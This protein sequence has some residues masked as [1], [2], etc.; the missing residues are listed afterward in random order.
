MKNLLIVVNGLIWLNERVISLSGLF[1][2]F[3][4][5]AWKNSPVKKLI[6]KLIDVVLRL[7]SKLR[8]YLEYIKDSITFRILYKK[9]TMPMDIYYREL[10][11]NLN[12]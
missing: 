6:F 1:L 2:S 12:K 7:F 8:G 11:N 3:S 4:L 9:V 10:K 5:K